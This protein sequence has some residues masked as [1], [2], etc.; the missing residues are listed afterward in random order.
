MRFLINS[1]YA[2]ALVF[3]EFII[4]LKYEVDFVW[5][6]RWSTATWIFVS[7]RYLMLVNV[8]SFLVPFSPQVCDA[9]SSLISLLTLS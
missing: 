6:K 9:N 3:Y 7:N 4:T 8:V 1:M 2:T 5:K